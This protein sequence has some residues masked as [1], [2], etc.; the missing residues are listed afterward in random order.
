M[1]LEMQAPTQ[2]GKQQRAQKEKRI[3]QSRITMIISNTQSK[4]MICH[5]NNQR[6]LISATYSKA[7][8]LSARNGSL[9][10]YLKYDA[11]LLNVIQMRKMLIK[12]LYI[13]SSAVLFFYD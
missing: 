3:M 4:Q 8:W 9:G 13:L 7:E 12:V 11:L 10:V 5:C 6:K 2:A 1:V